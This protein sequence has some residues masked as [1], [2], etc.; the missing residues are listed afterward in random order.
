MKWGEK[1]GPEPLAQLSSPDG[2]SVL[3]FVCPDLSELTS[4]G[5]GA[6]AQLGLQLRPHSTVI[7]AASRPNDLAGL[8]VGGLRENHRS[9]SVMW[10]L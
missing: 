8:K 7:I 5:E 1:Q 4:D 2:Q 9:G 3:C 6:D 10:L